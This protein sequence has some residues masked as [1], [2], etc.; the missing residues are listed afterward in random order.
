M[1]YM[2]RLF[3]LAVWIGLIFLALR[4]TP[5]FHW[6]FIAVALMPQALF[7][8][9]SQSAD[10]VTHALSI[11]LIAQILRLAFGDGSRR[12]IVL[13][14]LTTVLLALA[15]PGY[16]LVAALFLIV[17]AAK[18]GG[19]KKWIAAFAAIIGFGL[20]VTIGWAMISSGT[21]L[22]NYPDPNIKPA[23]QIQG[24]IRSPLSF[25]AVIVRTTSDQGEFFLK[26]M[27]GVLGWGDTPLPGFL[28]WI[29]YPLMF[30]LAFFGGGLD[31]R[32]GHRLA[33]IGV[34][35]LMYVFVATTA[36]VLWTPVGAKTFFG[37]QG[38]YFIPFIPVLFF[39]FARKRPNFGRA[40]VPY[41]CA[42]FAICSLVIALRT[43]FLRYYG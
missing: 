39:A 6:I 20:A 21:Y 5:A 2:G 32:P 12:A 4:I 9:A 11:L 30:G 8:A 19:Q 43:V 24:M 13:L 26:G 17:P 34:A 25:P 1:L 40:W 42:I 7:Q 28:P 29:F 22:S 41:A 16:F 3:N 27:F 36:Y 23:V 18:L 15:K 38:R 33:F 31:L 10:A 35:L 14:G 37:V